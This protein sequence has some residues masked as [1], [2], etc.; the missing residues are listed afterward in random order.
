MKP[1]V[2]ALSGGGLLGAAH[3]GVLNF[4]ESKGVRAAGVAGTSA[5]GLVASMYALDVP[6]ARVIQFGADVSKRP[7]EY[8]H[9]NTSGL[10]HE[11]W[12]STGEPA[13][14]LI[15]SSDFV[16]EL[17]S[18][19]GDVCATTDWTMP[20]ILTS[21]DLVSLK[22]QAFTNRQQV[23]PQRGQWEI[24]T[25]KPLTLAME[26]TMALPGLFA[27]PRYEDKVLVD[28]GTADTLPV[29]WAEALQLGVV[30][31]VEVATPS[32]VTAAQVGLTDVLSRA[33]SYATDTLS[34]LR[35]PHPA[36]IVVRP[37]T[38]NVPFF[39]FSDYN[40]LVEAGWTAMEQAWP[41]L[42]D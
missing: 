27:A 37:D 34:K 42:A 17:V 8:F 18:L 22:A 5:G 38:S 36:H 9:L 25:D 29:D 19:A 39:G 15:T 2:L 21:V 1:F 28:G 11:I 6:M 10:I 31:A 26:S 35:Q 16:K 23:R 30:L 41:E 4:L 40:R 32:W 12:P 7:R 33:E 13:T 20:A 24:L 3:L 14:G